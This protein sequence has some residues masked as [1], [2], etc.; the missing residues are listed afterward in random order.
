MRPV[1]WLCLS[2]F[3]GFSPS[4][5]GARNAPKS[6][7]ERLGVSR[8]VV[9]ILGDEGTELALQ[10][11]KETE[12]TLYVQ[13]EDAGALDS[14]RRAVADAGFSS[15]RIL[16][17][18]GTPSCVPLATH[19]A[20]AILSTRDLDD[21]A[22]VECLRAIRPGGRLILPRMTLNKPFPEGMD[23]WSHHYHGP[24]NNPQSK[25]QLAKA[26]FLT[27]FIMEPRYAPAPQAAVASSGRMFMAFG[28]VA[29]H[30][31]EEPW[32][33]T[34]VALNGFNG[35]LL[36]Q[37]PLSPG[38]MV[39]R[40]TLI[41][42]PAALYLGDEASCKVLDPATG[43]L[44]R[45]IKVPKRIAHGTFWK[46]MALEDG[47]LYALVG[48]DE[49][50]DE[51]KRWGMTNHGWPWSEISSGYRN[52]D[53]AWGK[54]G[55]LVAI[56][57]QRRDILWHN[58]NYPEIDS[59]ALCMK[60]GRI[61]LCSFGKVVACLDARNGKT[62]WEITPKKDTVPFAA[63]GPY[64]PTHGYVQGWKSTVYL[65]CTDQALYFVGPEVYRLTALSTEDGHVLWTYPV[66]DLHVVVR[67]EGLYAIGPQK[68][69]GEILRMDP[70]TG[71]ILETF[72]IHRRACTRTTGGLDSLYFRAFDGT[73]RFDIASGKPQ[74]ISP[75][76]PSCQVGVLVANGLLTWVPWAC[77]CGL[78][79]FGAIACAPA[80]DF[81]FSQEARAEERLETGP[82]RGG[83]SAP[84]SADPLDWPTLRADPLRSGTTQAEIPQEIRSLWSFQTQSSPDLTPP[85]MV[86]D[87]VLFSGTDGVVRALDAKSG[88]E[89]WSAFTGGPVLTPP[90]IADGCA[91]VGSCDGWAY[92][93]DAATGAL[94][95]RF[96][97]APEE[98]K[99]PVYG[100][101]C[102]T[103]PVA[104]GVLASDHVAYVASGMNNF[105]GTHVYALEISTGKILWQ[106]NTSGHLDAGS[107]TG[108]SVQGE[109]LLQGDR[110]YLAGGNAVSPGVYDIHTGQ[111]LN[112]PPGGLGSNAPR[113]RELSLKEDGTVAVTGQP[114]YSTPQT[115]VYDASV[116]WKEWEIRAKNGRLI[117][118]GTDTG[119]KLQAKS[120]E[121]ESILWSQDL[122]AEPVRW[123]VAMDHQGRIAVA[124]MN[125]QMMCFG[126]PE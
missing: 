32:L 97:A 96:R 86:G 15:E 29:W 24:D 52:P 7:A 116:A 42:D 121:A 71:E 85:V 16:I 115:T 87:R 119:W 43:E 67:E 66:R 84:S 30:S 126:S 102:S 54:G 124:L 91:L 41:A 64:R 77:D 94:I 105:D 31:R 19:L 100:T 49:P 47:I 20:D 79:M 14:A 6:L 113:G 99:I 123:G 82:G 56:D 44:L 57:I 117:C 109:M 36:W 118:A 68:E 106:N 89:H 73:V 59:R 76:R 81:D 95:W 4:V 46:W 51:T 55:T 90:S 17:E 38:I 112:D 104:G 74:W 53:Y 69:K 92:A 2:L 3:V 13:I 11:A 61:Y 108:V 75:M 111:C 62:L 103:W 107:R 93:F 80:G 22:R 50:R 120:L 125:G 21:P 65:R 40:C 5:S 63:I 10:L 9:A 98:R 114:L 58:D 37:R 8:G 27:Q 88:L 1:L 12:L 72:P 28:H 35:T 39:D 45:E 26:P 23:D 110:L 33:D 70:L 83:L 78:Q 60:N 18:K 34:L 25:D 122:P 48:A 101:L